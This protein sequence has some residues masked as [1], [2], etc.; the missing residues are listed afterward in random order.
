MDNSQVLEPKY[1][2]I[3]SILL[4]NNKTE[5]NEQNAINELYIPNFQRYYSW[6]EKEVTRLL[7]DIC[8]GYKNKEDN[9]NFIGTIQLTDFDGNNKYAVIDGQQRLTTISLIIIYLESKIN[10]FNEK[11]LKEIIIKNNS[12]YNEYYRNI[13]INKNNPAINLKDDNIYYKNYKLIGDY[14]KDIEND[15]NYN[16]LIEYIYKN[17]YIILIVS[18]KQKLSRI[19]KI[20]DTLNTTGLDLNS[21]DIFKFQ[22]AEYIVKNNYDKYEE[23]IDKITKQYERITRLNND[24]ENEKWTM[25]NVLLILQHILIIHNESHRLEDLKKSREKYFEDYFNDNDG[26]LSFDMF[27]TVIDV[28]EEIVKARNDE[29]IIFKYRYAQDILFWT[30][31]WRC[32]SYPYIILFYKKYANNINI[33][34]IK[35]ILEEEYFLAQ[36]LTVYSVLYNRYIDDVYR[37]YI[38]ILVDINKNIENYHNEFMVDLKLK[39][40]K[41]KP[42]QDDNSEDTSLDFKE[43]IE[44]NLHNT[45]LIC[46]WVLLFEELNHQFNPKELNKILFNFQNEKD[47]KYDVEH[48]FPQSRFPELQDKDK[49]YYCGIGN[50]TLLEQDINRKV[51]DNMKEKNK[52]YKKSKI[53]FPKEIVNDKDDEL[54]WNIDNIKERIKN[55]EDLFKNNFYI[56]DKNIW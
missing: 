47:Y 31:Y 29:T 8:E 48:I 44:K 22:F 16:E 36:F 25:D 39:A 12:Q 21:G 34:T 41:W 7:N 45:Y 32:W 24:Y 2:N 42:T 49:D 15:F 37:Y 38:N 33:E 30:R 53:S 17:L 50:L 56:I 55:I 1:C 9:F 20:F 19:I 5:N 40:K 13:Y 14:F 23:T 4:K 18:K 6:G 26:Y 51:Q 43:K 54:Q 10:K 28:I 52:E 46:K 27:K 11:S 35:T 3:E